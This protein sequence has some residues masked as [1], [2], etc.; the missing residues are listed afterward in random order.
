[1]TADYCDFCRAIGPEL[2]INKGAG[3]P[4]FYCDTECQMLAAQ[5]KATAFG[6]RAIGAAMD[7]RVTPPTAF[8]RPGV[9]FG[10]RVAGSDDAA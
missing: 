2:V 1:M 10:L 5:E 4:F 8:V 7:T 3:N 6:L 9:T